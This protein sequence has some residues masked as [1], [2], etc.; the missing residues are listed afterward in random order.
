MNATPRHTHTL[1]DRLRLPVDQPVLLTPG[2][3]SREQGQ[4]YAVWAAAL[5]QQFYPSIRL[6]LPG[7]SAER[8][9]LERFARSFRLPEILV[10]PG[11]SWTFDQLVSVA[12]VFVASLT[13]D[14]AMDG[15]LCAMVSG[16]PVVGS[17]VPSLR[18]RIADEETGLLVP[19]R[20]P[21]HL[22]GAILR[23]Y[24]D[25]ALRSRL[26]AAAQQRATRTYPVPPITAVQPAELLSPSAPVGQ[27]TLGQ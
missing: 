18:R 17:D 11:D 24:E 27:T 7:E 21:T 8:R 14:T 13:V 3:P 25:L 20:K 9:R 12:D 2:P 4:Y 10:C 22:A 15:L 26:A 5:L 19:P 1:R 23:I 16:L 6:I